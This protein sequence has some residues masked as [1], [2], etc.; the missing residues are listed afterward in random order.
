MNGID[1]LEALD[2]LESRQLLRNVKVVTSRSGPYVEVDGRRYLSFC[3]NDYLGL[4]QHPRLIEA[5]TDALKRFGVGAS[6]S[7]VVCGH[8]KWHQALEERLIDRLPWDGALVFT[9]GYSANLAIIQALTGRHDSIFQ[10]RLNHASLLDGARL[11]GA[12]LVRFRHND[13]VDLANRLRGFTGRG[14][15]VSDG[16]FSMDGD[17]ADVPALVRA[18][19]KVSLPVLIDDAHGFGVLG[20]GGEGT[21]VSQGVCPADVD[22]NVVTLGK[23]V[24]ASGAVVM[25]SRDAIAWLRQKARPHIYTTAMPPCIAAAAV[26]ALDVMVDESWRRSYLRER[27]Q[28][29]RRGATELGLDV[30]ASDTPIQP[31][32]LGGHERALRWSNHLKERGLWVVAI[33]PPTVS[34][35][36]SRLRVTLSAEHTPE[37][38]DRLLVALSEVSE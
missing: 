28:Q 35:G 23:A 2:G 27:I 32:L 3:S 37:E 7:H 36:E 10:D 1:F 4:A 16:V 5:A 29:F 30:L 24:G 34:V 11:S 13:P 20:A 6:A 21:V 26:E 38:I 17:V 15:V 31:I 9:S 25:G 14:L 22:F 19:K 8:S 12:K 18:A 33:R